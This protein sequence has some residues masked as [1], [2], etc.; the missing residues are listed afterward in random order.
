MVAVKNSLNCDFS[1]KSGHFTSNYGIVFLSD[2]CGEVV[3][4]VAVTATATSTVLK[5]NKRQHLGSRVHRVHSFSS[6]TPRSLFVAKR[7]NSKK[8]M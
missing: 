3:V 1:G 8:K 6:L 4:V 5:A 2:S 7:K